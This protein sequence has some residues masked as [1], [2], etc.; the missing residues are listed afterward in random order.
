[1]NKMIT[2]K[3]VTNNQELTLIEEMAQV[4]W[5]EHYTPIIG[6]EQVVYML[7]KFQTANSMAVQISKG[8]EYF[9]ILNDN[10]PVGY[11][12]FEKRSRALFLS[13]IYLLKSSRGKGFGRKAMRFIEEQAKQSHCSK[14]SLTVNKYNLNSIKA[15]ESAGFI[16]IGAIVQDIGNGFVMDD[17]EMEKYI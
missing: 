14:I 17:Y 7:K 13:K 15:Y 8:Y 12:S 11:L 6:V 9:L 1:M 5:H 3:S 16:N 4:I 2:F 10:S